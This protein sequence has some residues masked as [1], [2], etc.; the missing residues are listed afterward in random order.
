MLL[1]LLTMLHLLSA[2][3]AVALPFVSGATQQGLNANKR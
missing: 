1:M 2:Q 3:G